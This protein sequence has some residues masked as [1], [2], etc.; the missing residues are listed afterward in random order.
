MDAVGAELLKVAGFVVGLA[1]FPAA[2]EDA[3][4]FEGQGADG[5]VVAFEGGASPLAV[6]PIRYEWLNVDQPCLAAQNTATRPIPCEW[7]V[8]A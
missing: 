6:D 8:D 4:P 7:L 2:E 3:D 1:I 5:G